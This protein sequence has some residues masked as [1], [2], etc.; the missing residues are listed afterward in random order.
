MLS[1]GNATS[2]SAAFHALRLL[3]MLLWTKHSAAQRFLETDK[4]FEMAQ[5]EIT[6]FCLILSTCSAQS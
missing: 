1:L 3:L 6:H 4:T 2:M 5:S